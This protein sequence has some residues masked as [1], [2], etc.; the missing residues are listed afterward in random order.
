MLYSFSGPHCILLFYL[1]MYFSP[2]N[3]SVSYF[4]LLFS[5]EILFCLMISL[6]LNALCAFLW[7]CICCP[8]ISLVLIMFCLF[9]W[10]CVCHSV[11]SLFCCLSLLSFNSQ[12]FGVLFWFVDKLPLQKLATLLSLS[13]SSDWV[14]SSSIGSFNT[15][16][17]KSSLSI[18]FEF[19]PHKAE[20]SA[21]D[22]RV[23]RSVLSEGFLLYLLVQLLSHL[24]NSH[25]TLWY[26]SLIYCIS[27]SL[28]QTILSAHVPCI[29]ILDKYCNHDVCVTFYELFWIVC[30]IPNSCSSKLQRTI[31]ITT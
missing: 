10:S 8:I 11:L 4:A 14:L 16:A 23:L 7:T 21:L 24:W 30:Q 13:V 25:L 17:L 26:K 22:L 29:D 19:W 18:L 6:V 15:D 27:H 5:L 20:H 12:V 2:Y 28:Y 1:E 3:F 9:F 31:W